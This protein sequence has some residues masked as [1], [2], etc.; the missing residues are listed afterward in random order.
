V[1]GLGETPSRRQKEAG[2]TNARVVHQSGNACGSAI[3]RAILLEEGAIPADIPAAMTE[4]R[5][6]FDRLS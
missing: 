1:A 3:D 5:S 6:E 4:N 2:A